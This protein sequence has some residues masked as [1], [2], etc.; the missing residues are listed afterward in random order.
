MIELPELEVWRRELERELATKKIASVELTKP[1]LLVGAKKSDLLERAQGAKVNGVD[2]IGSWLV[3]RLVTGGANGS[4][5]LIAFQ[6]GA[7][8]EIRRIATKK[9]SKARKGEGAEPAAAAV[10]FTI[11]PTQGA[12][13]SFADPS[14]TS[15]LRFFPADQLATEIPESATLGLDVVATPVSWVTFGE[16]LIQRS[17]RLKNVLMDQTFV[18]GL[19]TMYSDEILF[20]AGLRYDRA[21]KSLSAQEIRRLYR[22]VVEVLH[23]AVKHGGTSFGDDGFRNLNGDLGG[24]RE[25]LTVFKRDGEMSPRARG[26]IVK[27]RFGS[28]YT[29]FCEQTQM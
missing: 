12:P 21:T 2:R 23:D 16:E 20:G 17:G 15:V 4:S 10:A 28:G 14:D 26:P 9:P 29:Y 11:T 25:L 6:P 1:K 8:A 13:I 7:Q 27:A 19:G 24:Y 5:D 22:S 18:V 3:L